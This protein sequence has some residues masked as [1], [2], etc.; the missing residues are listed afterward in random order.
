MILTMCIFC[1]FLKQISFYTK[2]GSW[3][4]IVGKVVGTCCAMFRG[5]VLQLLVLSMRN[6]LLG[7]CERNQFC[8]G[9]DE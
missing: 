6:Y 5:D 3:S 9:V 1:L 7:Y 4:N 8:K 2:Y